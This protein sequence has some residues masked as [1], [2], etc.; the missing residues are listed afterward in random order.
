MSKKT[1]Q[2][3]IWMLVAIVAILLLCVII[4]DYLPELKLFANPHGID[5]AKLEAMVRDH[6][7]KDM[8]ILG[9]MI[10]IMCAVPGMSNAVICVV[11]GICYG[12]FIGFLLNWTGNVLGNE[13]SSFL[14][15]KFHFKAHSERI[16]QLIDNNHPNIMMTVGYMIPFIP[17][18]GINYYAAVRK[19][20]K[21]EHLCMVMIGMIPTALLYALGGD[22]ILKV[23]WKRLAVVVVIIV[24]LVGFN[25]FLIREIK[26]RRRLKNTKVKGSV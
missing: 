22:A 23:N 6:G 21:K 13:M 14:L 15:T 8:F 19:I 25:A 7:F 1:K 11:A 24:I 9:F 4:K 3:L 20:S 10:M 2:I 16:R 5:Q 26:K 12:P 17:S 18:F